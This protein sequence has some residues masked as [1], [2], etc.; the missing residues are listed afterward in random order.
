MVLP[1]PTASLAS[2]ASLTTQFV[3][4][5]SIAFGLL[6]VVELGL[7]AAR[8]YVLD[9]WGGVI[10]SLISVFGFFV[11]R[12]RFDLQ[13]T[14]MFGITIFFYGLIHF[15]MLLEKAILS[16]GNFPETQAGPRPLTRDILLIAA[17]VVDWALSSLCVY[18]FKSASSAIYST[19]D[20]RQPLA[21][22]SSF[23]PFSGQGRKLA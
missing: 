13:W 9:I 14:I 7:S 6:L 2:S 22:A 15:V 1:I 3:Q 23:T 16:W 18:T 21:A 19:P 8:F 17:P 11:V 5:M 4:R 10:M 20:E 12:F